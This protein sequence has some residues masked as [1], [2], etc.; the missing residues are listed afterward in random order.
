M[1]PIPYSLIISGDVIHKE[2]ENKKPS[3]NQ[4]INNNLQIIWR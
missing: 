4:Q 1:E 3:T 2:N